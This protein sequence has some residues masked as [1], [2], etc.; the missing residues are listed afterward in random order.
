MRKQLICTLF[1]LLPLFASAA[2]FPSMESGQYKIACEAEWTKK[3]VLDRDMFNYCVN[4]K[5]EGYDKALR[6]I[7]EFKNEPWIQDVIDFAI[8]K[9]TKK[10]SRDDQMVAFTLQKE[11]DG[12]EELVLASTKANFNKKLF[13]ACSSHW[14][15]QFSMFWNCSA[16]L[17]QA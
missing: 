11:I 2:T 10:G 9:W 6:L 8:Q 12:F 7:E 3:G 1:G 5:K 15:V 16:K 17:H 4:N 13:H 14:G